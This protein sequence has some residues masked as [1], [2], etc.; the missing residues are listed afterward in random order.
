MK[1][2][3]PEIGA[4]TLSPEAFCD[5]FPFHIVTDRNL[6][7]LQVGRSIQK[8]YPEIEL[9]ERIDTAFRIV[10]P[11]L[12]SVDWGVLKKRSATVYQLVCPKDQ[13]RLRGQVLVDEERGCAVFLTTPWITELSELEPLGLT[14]K[15]FAIHDSVAD[16]LFLLRTRDASIADARNKAERLREQSKRLEQ[17]HREAEEANQAKSDFLATI[18]HEIRTPMNGVVGMAQL[19]LQ[20]VLDQE[21]VGFVKTIDESATWLL[22]ILND[23]LDVSKIEA[24]KLSMQSETFSLRSLVAEAVRLFEGQCS[25]S[26]VN[27]RLEINDNVP[28]VVAGDAQRLRQVLSNLVGNAAKFTKEGEVLVSVSAEKSI[29]DTTEIEFVVEDTGIG[30]EPTALSKIFDA[31]IQGDSTT[32]RQF[33]G[34]G[35]GL[36][37]CHGLTKMMG[38]AISVSSAPGKGSVFVVRLPFSLALDQKMLEEKSSVAP[39]RFAGRKVL[40]AEDN[41][42][43]Q[44]VAATM[45]QKY[46]IDCSIANNGLEAV[47]RFSKETF[48]LIL[49]DYHMPL[50][51]GPGAVQEIRSQENA[52]VQVGGVPIVALTANVREQDRKICF[53]AGMN[54]FLSKPVSYAKLGEV[55]A[56]WF[57]VKSD[58][59]DS[60]GLA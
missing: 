43:N 46:G 19:L 41:P 34:T 16:F 45:L 10:R 35:L 4:Y 24:G 2:K 31:F 59:P 17:A 6:S 52:G 60:P 11:A 42:V 12:H 51:D 22:S 14:L 7:I 54:D 55:L 29:G 27:L 33:G 39:E 38:G 5:A 18:S 15:D 20:S 9:G 47:E 37:I 56:R 3:E 8:A 57:D 25:S 44:R 58:S 40:L 48:D 32:T 49:M 36:A 26:G 30:I 28:R 53:D 13:L 50:L 21:R 23:I 1:R